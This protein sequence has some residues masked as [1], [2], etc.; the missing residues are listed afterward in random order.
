MTELTK[1]MVYTASLDSAFCDGIGVSVSTPELSV[2]NAPE[3]DITAEAIELLNERY[4][5]SK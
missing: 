3:Y 4:N 1:A 5:K 2:F